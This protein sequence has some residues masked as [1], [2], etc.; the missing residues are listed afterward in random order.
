MPNVMIRMKDETLSQTDRLQKKFGAPSRS[1]VIRRAIDL[2]DAISGA[3]H[4]GDKIIIE[5]NGERRE[6]IIPGLTNER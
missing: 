5:G 1:D 2:S 3:V 6:I 4:K